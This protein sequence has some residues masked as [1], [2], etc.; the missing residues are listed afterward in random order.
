MD[1]TLYFMKLEDKYWGLFLAALLLLCIWGGRQ[2]EKR[3]WYLTACYG[4][5]SYLVFLCP[6]T[7][8]LVA[9]LFP[10]LESCYYE[11]G[12]IWL[13]IG[14]LP[15]VFTAT[16]EWLDGKQNARKEQLYLAVGGFLILLA[17]GE[18]AYF[19]PMQRPERLGIY[20]AAQTQAYDMILADA[21][22]NGMEHD[23]SLWGPF[24]FMAGSRVYDASFL[25][26][27]GKDIAVD[28]SGYHD[29]ARTL[30]HGY[31][32]YEDED[33]LLINKDQQLWAIAL[34]MNLYD[35]AACRYVVILDPAS[36]GSDVDADPIF[37]ECKFVSVGQAGDY[38]IYRYTGKDI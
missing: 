38:R 5:L 33:S 17:A 26:V 3:R 1:I 4:M 22:K 2:R 29:I 27:Y 18:F 25:P 8:R 15:L 30:Y 32:S 13:V 20:E 31:T 11:L 14:I 10:A 7:Y 37:A 35:E 21:Q 34:F 24:D 23:I 6:L 19:Q 36:Q 12:H 16:W 28:E 9:K